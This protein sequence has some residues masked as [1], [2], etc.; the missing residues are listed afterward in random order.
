MWFYWRLFYVASNTLSSKIQWK[1][2]RN[3]TLRSL[4]IHDSLIR[5]LH[6]GQPCFRCS[7]CLFLA[8]SG[9]GTPEIWA[10]LIFP[11]IC[12]PKL[13]LTCDSANLIAF[14][15]SHSKILTSYDFSESI[16]HFSHNSSRTLSSPDKCDSSNSK[17][18]SSEESV[19]AFAPFARIFWIYSE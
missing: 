16:G 12:Y 1:K 5:H 17:V 19:I 3:E 11:S 6:V 10:A 9:K 4:T 8:S 15:W 2:I 18:P 13:C 14:H 7:T